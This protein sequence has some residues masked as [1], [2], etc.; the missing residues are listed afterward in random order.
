[1]SSELCAASSF[2]G[3]SWHVNKLHEASTGQSAKIQASTVFVFR[4]LDL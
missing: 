3:D 4:D 2:S 1:M